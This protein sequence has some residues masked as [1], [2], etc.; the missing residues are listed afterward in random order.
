MSYSGFNCLSMFIYIHLMR[1]DS[2]WKKKKKKPSWSVHGDV[3]SRVTV[4]T[5]FIIP[6]LQRSA[7]S[8]LLSSW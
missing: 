3:V 8:R 6:A 7:L 5:H 4:N 1:Q 2:F